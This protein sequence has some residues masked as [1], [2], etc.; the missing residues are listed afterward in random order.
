[1]NIKFTTKVFGAVAAAL[2][3]STSANAAKCGKVTIADMNWA[4][5]SLMAN[6]DKAM[7]EAM[8]CE[9]ELVAGATMPTFTS[10][11]ETGQPDVAPEIWANAMADLV[12]SAVGACLLYTSPSPRDQRGSRMPSS[13]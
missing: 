3:L 4:S 13:A 12:D 8:G 11:N 5:A 7:L 2:L 1:M 9:V 10:M 6:V